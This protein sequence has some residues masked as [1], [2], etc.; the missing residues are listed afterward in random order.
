[1]PSGKLIF[2]LGITTM[3]SY[4]AFSFLWLLA[5]IPVPYPISV[6]SDS[7]YLFQLMTPPIGALLMVIGGLICGKK[8]REVSS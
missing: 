1:M 2:I 4:T 3:F 8:G 5:G 6:D 7:F